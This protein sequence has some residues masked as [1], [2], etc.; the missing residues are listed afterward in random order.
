MTGAKLFVGAFDAGEELLRVDSD[1]AQ[2]RRGGGAVVAVGAGIGGDGF[3]EVVKQR[4]PAA[5]PL[6]F[7]KTDDRI[8]MLDS[9]ALFTPAF[10]LDEI[11]QLG[12]VRVAVEQ[13]AVRRQAIPPGAPDLLVVALDAFRQVEVDHK[14]DVGL[15]DP[16]AKGDRRYHDLG[17]VANKGFLV[18]PP[19]R[20]FEPGMVGTD[21][22]SL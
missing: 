17:I 10:L 22:I 16:H 2:R 8:Q 13:Q 5:G 19:L 7:R 3:A 4:L 12:D 15:V 18:P 14:A 11:I 20:I 21:R 6:I 1:V 9:N